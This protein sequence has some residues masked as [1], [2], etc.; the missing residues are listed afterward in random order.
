MEPKPDF[1]TAHDAPGGPSRSRWIAGVLLALALGVLAVVAFRRGYLSPG[2][3]NA[4]LDTNASGEEIHAGPDGSE[5]PAQTAELTPARHAQGPPAEQLAMTLPP[6]SA[7]SQRLIQEMAMLQ[8]AD[9]KLRP[10]Q[11]AQLREHLYALAE[12][13]AA[14]I[15][16]IRQ[17]LDRNQDIDFDPSGGASVGGC[18]S[19]RA[20]LLDTL[21]HIGGPEAIETLANA[22]RATADP[23]EIHAIA[24]YLENLAPGQYRQ[25]AVTAARET[26]DRTLRGHLHVD[27]AGPL[28]EVLQ[29]RG[30]A[31]V[32]AD[33]SAAAPQWSYYS[34]MALAGLADAQGIPALAQRVRDPAA[35]NSAAD[36]FALQMLAQM[37]GQFPDAASVLIEQARQNQLSDAGWAKIAEGLAGE[38][39]RIGPTRAVAPGEGVKTYHIARG[40]Q[41]FHSVPFNPALDPEQ[42]AL[43]R[44]I[45]DEL[46]EVAQSPTAIQAL[47][48]ARTGL[49]PAN[50]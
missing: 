24:R 33:L 10:E 6:E 4:S 22:L 8:F 14:A 11:A 36:L 29:S 23:S 18:A 42:T 48:S 7:V 38:Q 3:S 40:N 47:R 17:F 44:A 28:F 37:A 43:R 41:N 35:S 15:P 45:I 27:D 39:Y 19:L 34:T 26:L 2:S 46:L 12:E 16:A 9:G 13:G 32:V 21:N 49:Q 50:P 31:E 25:E 30:D 20:G 5:T 1:R